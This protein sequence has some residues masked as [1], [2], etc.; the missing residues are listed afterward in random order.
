MA[1]RDEDRLTRFLNDLEIPHRTHHHPPVHTVADARALRGDIPAQHCKCLFL[2]DK[3][4]R[5]LL[6]LAP[7][8][9]PVDLVALADRLGLGRLSFASADSLERVLGIKPGAVT[10]FGLLNAQY[11][12]HGEPPFRVAMDRRL[13]DAAQVAF[14]PLHNAATTCLSP[15]DLT[16]FMLACGY[17]PLVVDLCGT[18]KD[19]TDTS[20]DP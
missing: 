7:E 2:R 17:Q 8:D 15:A 1:T 10:P 18:G 6:M 20:P 11:P 12:P 5:R 9:S 3:K 16:R 13:A 19:G 14:H 4:K